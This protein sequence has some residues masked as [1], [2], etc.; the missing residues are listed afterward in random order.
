MNTMT[1]TALAQNT[2]PG[3]ELLSKDLLIGDPYRFEDL[4][5]DV[6]FV[7]T[8]FIEEAKK[9]NKFLNNLSTALLG[10]STAGV[11]A[12]SAIATVPQVGPQ[13]AIPFLGISA[14]ALFL[15]AVSRSQVDQTLEQTQP[16]KL[17][18]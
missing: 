11:G 17:S 12:A 1:S 15:A 14:T 8:S 9:D 3:S 16:K 10:F 5:V 13:I 6:D 2:G 4:Q 7:D 18:M